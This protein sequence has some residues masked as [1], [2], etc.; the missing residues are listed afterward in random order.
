MTAMKTSVVLLKRGF[1]AMFCPVHLRLQMGHAILCSKGCS[2]H[3]LD[4]K[5][6]HWQQSG[7]AVERLANA[8]HQALVV[9][10]NVSEKTTISLLLR[11]RRDGTS[12][13]DAPTLYKALMSR[14]FLHVLALSSLGR[15]VGIVPESCVSTMW[16]ENRVW[17]NNKSNSD[18][19]DL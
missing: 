7:V 2:P 3:N 5:R 9:L 1:L 6:R 10:M 11:K 12:S 13:V 14:C 16:H 8:T 19:N 17:L 4:K 15:L 18:A